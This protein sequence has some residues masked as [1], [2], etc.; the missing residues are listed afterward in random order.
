MSC[1][2]TTDAPG[3]N[4]HPGISNKSYINCISSDAGPNSK[5]VCQPKSPLNNSGTQGRA[6]IFLSVIHSH[7]KPP[8]P[9]LQSFIHCVFFW[10]ILFIF[11]YSFFSIRFLFVAYIN[12]LH[13]VYISHFKNIVQLSVML[14]CD[15]IVTVVT[16][17]EMPRE[18]VT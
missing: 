1:L 10:P 3:K 6:T 4:I 11:F 8:R 5:A 2:A 14:A 13:V 18:I 17:F 16:Y 12:L 15:F 7:R 9:L